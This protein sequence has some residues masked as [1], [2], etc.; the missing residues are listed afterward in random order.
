M[1]HV[2][3]YRVREYE[4]ERGASP[5]RHWLDALDLAAKARIQARVLRVESG[6]L[7]DHKSVGG[8]V[9]ELRLDF[10]P[11]FRVYF[12][13]EGADLVLLLIGGDKGSQ[14]RDISK[15]QQFWQECKKGN[16]DGTKK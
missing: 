5:Y 6:N 9:M 16:K 1:R 10:G 2:R 4:D 15:A 7:G 3:P 12:G 14:R 11:G 8:G 13:L